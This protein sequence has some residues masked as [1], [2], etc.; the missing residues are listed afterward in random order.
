MLDSGNQ[1][2]GLECLMY[3]DKCH[4]NVLK[5]IDHKSFYPFFRQHVHQKKIFFTRLD[6]FVYEHYNMII[7]LGDLQLAKL[8]WA[9]HLS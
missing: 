5:I 9:G 2:G 3:I 6:M 8:F 1:K 7:V 4:F